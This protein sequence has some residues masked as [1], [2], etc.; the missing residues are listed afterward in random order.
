MPLIPLPFVV[1]LLLM[2]LFVVLLRRDEDA[3]PNLPFLGLI[4]G[5]AAQSVLAGLRWGYGIESAGWLRPVVAAALPALLSA[6]FGALT[7]MEGSRVGI[8]PHAFPVGLVAGLLVIRPTAVDGVLIAIYVIYGV[9]LLW[10]GRSGPDVLG[11]ARL[12]GAAGAWRALQ[13][14]G[15]ALLASAVVDGIV[16]WDLVWRQGRHAATIVG[17]ANVGAL[18]M[19]GMSAYLAGLARPSTEAA[20]LVIPVPPGAGNLDD[21]AAT[22]DAL[23]RDQ[24]LYRD[25]NLNLNRLARRA[26]IP[27]RRI[28]SAVNRTHGRNVSQYINSH[29]IAEACRR[30]ET[31]DEPVTS[32]MFDVGFQTKSNFN[33]EFRRITGKSPV[34]WRMDARERQAREAGARSDGK[35]VLA[36]RRLP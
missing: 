10:V 29:R 9:A 8:W 35:S 17:V 1:A 2:A 18:F 13:M 28:S 22:V 34:A 33:R 14:G 5:C 27:A 15:G 23:M 16:V 3:P 7:R 11:Q 32:V 31:T 24:Q 4:A 12:D 6:S 26:G 30:L 21:V 25:V 20:E 36:H 19:L